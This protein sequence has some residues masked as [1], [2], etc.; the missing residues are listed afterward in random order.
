M[1]KNYLYVSSTTETFRKHFTDMAD[2]LAGG[3]ALQGNSLVVDIGS[4]DGLLLQKFKDKG[5]RV[6]GVEPADNLCEIARNNGID[7][8]NGFFDENIVNDITKM[9]GKADLVTANNVFAHIN[10]VKSV[11]KNPSNQLFLK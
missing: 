6:V 3:L 2:K 11:I 9:K 1:F 10:D 5:M 7:T 4:N 8:I